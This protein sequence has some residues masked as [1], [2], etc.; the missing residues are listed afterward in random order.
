MFAP[1]VPSK[2][3]ISLKPF[4]TLNGARKCKLNLM[5]YTKITPGILLTGPL[6]IIWLGVNGFFVS[7]EIRIA[8]LIVTRHD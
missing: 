2:P 8:A 4:V 1:Y 3:D 5:P 6:L 7:N